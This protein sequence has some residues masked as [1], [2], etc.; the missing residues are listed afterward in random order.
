M[1]SAT[2]AADHAAHEKSAL[3]VVS[4]WHQ[5]GRR[6]L[7]RLKGLQRVVRTLL[8]FE[9]NMRLLVVTNK[10][11]Q[12]ITDL[13]AE[14]VIRERPWC[15]GDFDNY[16]LCW[17]AIRVMR[18]GSTGEPPDCD[19][20][21]YASCGDLLYDY[22]IYL[23]GDIV[24]PANSFYFWTAHVDD[25]YRRGYLLQPHR[26][27]RWPPDRLTD[28]FYPSC[29]EETNA[30]WDSTNK[31]LYSGDV[32]E[33]IYLNPG[34]TQTSC[35]LMTKTQFQDYLTGD[36]WDCLRKNITHPAFT[37]QG[38]RELWSIRAQASGGLIWDPRFGP[39]RVLIHLLM[40]TYHL[41]PPLFR[42]GYVAG[43]NGSDGYGA[44]LS[45]YF[46][47]ADQCAQD[48][49][50]CMKLDEKDSVTDGQG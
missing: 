45:N 29:V 27:E 35:F 20:D 14:Q 48:L 46:V 41:F 13:G 36:E 22:Y 12:Q 11:M 6:Y 2:S 16:C 38:N 1:E 9:V 5:V 25:L 43:S 47:K 4:Y 15:C 24:L 23:E 31:D 26:Q 17:E 28:C 10:F 21:N 18:H 3:A 34:N 40:P 33:R 50:N 7:G 19:L 44:H 8:T 39:H 30:L 37:I 32:H 49:Q 42:Y